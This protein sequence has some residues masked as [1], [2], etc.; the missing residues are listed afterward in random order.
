MNNEIIINNVDPQ[1]ILVNGGGAQAYGIVDVLVNGISVVTNNVANVTVPTKTSEL[2][3]DSG[4][5]TTETDPTVP[6][7]IKNITQANINSWNNKQELLVSGTNIKTLNNTSLLGSG[8]IDLSGD[9]YIAGNGININN[10][11][12]SNTITRYNDLTDLP[13]I[14]TETSQLINNSNFVVSSDL[15]EVAFNGSYNALSDTPEI[16]DSTSDL[17]NDSNFAVTNVNNNFSA[18]QNIAGNLEITGESN[19]NK[20]STN[21]ILIGKWIDGKNL[22]RK[23]FNLTLP[24]NATGNI[25]TNFTTESIKNIIGS[26]SDGVRVYPINY[27]DQTSHDEINTYYS[28]SYINF[29]TNFDGSNYTGYVTL[30]YT[31]D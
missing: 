4:F 26:V 19:L 1:Q 17:I 29:E 2:V 6:S 18:S 25:N 24:N 7:Y 14:P 27:H 20:F 3:N 15:A 16:P 9:N 8:N 22:Y 12:I 10:G 5:I 30:E 31:K 21:E 28:N 23:S 13:S 11:V